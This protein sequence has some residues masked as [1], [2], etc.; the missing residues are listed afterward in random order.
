MRLSVQNLQLAYPNMRLTGMKAVD[1]VS[2][3]LQPAEAFGIVGESGCG[4]SSLAKMIA[5]LAGQRAQTAGEVHLDGRRIDHQSQR[6]WRF[7]RQRLQ[8][9]FQDPLGALDPRMAI[10]AQVRAPLDI[11]GIG[12]RRE[13]TA[14]AVALLTSVGLDAHLHDSPPLALSGGQR[15]RVVLARALASGPDVLLC[16]EPVS[17][18]DVSVQAQI[19][20]LLGEV[21]K[22]LGLT[23]LFIS[24]DLA[25]VR[26]ICQRVAVMYLG[27]FV[28][29]GDIDDVFGAPAHPYTRALIDSVPGANRGGRLRLKGNASSSGTRPQGC[30]FAARCPMAAARCLEEDP[31]LA[32]LPDR[33]SRR[34]ACHFPL[35]SEA[36]A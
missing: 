11:H 21:R 10:R 16:D 17:A 25:V 5:G 35:R 30:A 36:A 3:D 27:R 29:I 28:E 22:R 13:R 8:Y 23:M 9:V 2:F 20:T 4:K 14:R 19:L 33:E 15:Q 18:L 7:T 34:V 1:G 12:E 24:H 26:Y 6:E 32:P 31:A